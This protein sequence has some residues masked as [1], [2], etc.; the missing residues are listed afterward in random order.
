MRKLIITFLS[1]FVFCLAFSQT[2][3]TGPTG[4]RGSTGPTGARGVSGVTGATGSSGARGVT[5]PTGARG[6]TGPTGSRF[7]IGAPPTDTVTHDGWMYFIFPGIPGNDTVRV[8][9]FQ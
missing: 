6:A 4:A 9:Y 7:V 8:K 2:G 3:P 1:L 5:G